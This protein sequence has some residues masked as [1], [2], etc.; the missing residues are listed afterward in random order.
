MAKK[1]S[2][3]IIK[4]TKSSNL[5]KK[6]APKKLVSSRPV[7]QKITALITPLYDRVLIQ[8]L[9]EEEMFKTSALGIIIPDSGKDEGGKRG[10]VIAVGEGRVDD[11]VRIPVSVEVGQTVL[12]SWGDK[13]KVGGDEFVIVRESEIIAILNL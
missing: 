4:R 12:Y 11:G 9:G 2:K 7:N 10:K 13:I 6:N 3:K 8:E 1:T 5:N